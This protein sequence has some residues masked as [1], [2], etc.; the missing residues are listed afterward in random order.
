[1]SDVPET[2]ALTLSGDREVRLRRWFAAP[3][4]LVFEAWTTPGQ[5][6]RFYGPAGH[7]LVACAV[8]LRP[9]GAY[10]FVGA[11]P[12]GTQYRMSGIYEA[13]DRP[14]AIA[15]TERYGPAGAETEPAM[16]WVRLADADGGTMLTAR[17]RYPTPAARRAV[18][19]MGMETGAGETYD[20]LSLHLADVQGVGPRRPAASC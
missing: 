8:D 14:R 18:L 17:V 10:S 9:G 4:A 3:P 7:R 11:C 6:R 15:F 16:V 2:P 13:I 12:E 19:A 20:R 1:M 5:L